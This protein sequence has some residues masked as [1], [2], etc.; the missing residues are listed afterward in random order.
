M[1]DLGHWRLLAQGHPQAASVEMYTE[2][3]VTRIQALNHSF[4]QLLKTEPKPTPRG[5]CTHNLD[6]NKASSEAGVSKL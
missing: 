3:P 2:R 1:C 4:A 6:I 5:H